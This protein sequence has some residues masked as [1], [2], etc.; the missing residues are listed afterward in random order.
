MSVLKIAAVFSDKAVAAEVAGLSQSLMFEAAVD[1]TQHLPFA[2]LVLGASPKLM[3]FQA[4]ADVGL[5][6]VSERTLKNQPLSTLN[7]DQLPGS[8]GVFPMVASPQ[9]GPKAADKHWHE[10][11]GPLALEVHSAMTHYY[12]LT[13]IHRFTGADWN[14]LALC[15]FE[16]EY[17]FRNKF[18]NSAE[19]K[20]R[21]AE[22]VLKFA[23]TQNSPR[24]VVTRLMSNAVI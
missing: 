1:D 11:H 16:S 9:I 12:Q 18:Y 20:Q 10:H 15:C 19:G 2:A 22:D 4:R 23:D 24:R 7:P 3:D 6:L 14:G 21:V 13:V 8:V 5:F 17:D